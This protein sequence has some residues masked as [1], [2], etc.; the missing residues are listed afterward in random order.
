MT[1]RRPTAD[2]EHILR[3]IEEISPEA[4]RLI[5]HFR[6][7]HRRGRKP[8][9]ER[10]FRQLHLWWKSFRKHHGGMPLEQAFALF[11]HKHRNQ[12]ANL[13]QIK[14][15]NLRSFLNAV[16]LGAAQT[17]SIR[18]R[19]RATWFVLRGLGGSSFTTDPHMTAY[20]RAAQQYALLGTGPFKP[21][22]S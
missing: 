21:P 10:N 5:A 12:I 4:A 16:A 19:R 8:I 3:Q 11:Q 6:G 14:R 2:D 7:L 17:E 13:L 15:E 9:P 20:L 22:F 18:Q 1:A